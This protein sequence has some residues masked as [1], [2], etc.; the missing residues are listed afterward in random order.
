MK[1]PPQDPI[2]TAETK[3]RLEKETL[4]EL[5]TELSK[6][7]AQTIAFQSVERDQTGRPS[8]FAAGNRRLAAV[9]V[10]LAA[11]RDEEAVLQ[12]KITAQRAVVASAEANLRRFQSAS[13]A[14][15]VKELLPELHVMGR[16]LDEAC[17]VLIS[18]YGEVR[19][20]MRAAR[21]LSGSTAPTSWATRSTLVQPHRTGS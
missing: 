8:D 10:Q 7:D 20:A 17:Q 11:L 21:A 4:A 16:R 15:R 1:S 5:L 6:L 12:V 13:G 19:D 18:T 9:R 2:A 14:S 3:L